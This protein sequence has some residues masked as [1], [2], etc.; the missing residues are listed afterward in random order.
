MPASWKAL[1]ESQ[2]QGLWAL[3]VVPA[4]FLVALAVRGGAR[5]GGVAPFA[6]RFVRAWAVAFALESVL[7]PIATGPLGWP[8]VPFVLLGDFRVFALV[9]VV[10]QPGRARV[11]ALLEAALWTCLV[12]AFAYPL[13]RAI[14]HVHGPA[15]ETILWLLYEVA[16]AVLAISLAVLLVPVRV[17]PDRPTVRRY[18]YEV[19]AYVA[20]YYALWAIADVVVLTGRD[21]G[22]GLRIV[23]NLLYYGGFVPLAYWRFFAARYA[24]SSSSTQASR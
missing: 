22:W 15:P 17:G 6:A 8:L 7:D 13:H 3:I 18:L 12:P 14:E 10:A 16:F 23:P 11:G 20:V 1:Y 2:A 9:L 19:L 4:L 24:R 5:G 21:W